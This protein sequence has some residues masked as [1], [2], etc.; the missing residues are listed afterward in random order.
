MT[1]ADFKEGETFGQCIRGLRR[2]RN[3]TQRDLAAQLG[4]DFTYLSKLE[5]DRGEIPAETTVRRLA[6]LLDVDPEELLSL[7]GRVPSE[8]RERAR[9]DVEFARFLRSLPDLPDDEVQR[10]HKSLKKRSP[11]K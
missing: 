9:D 6:E 4:I 11:G 7:A 1:A 10:L 3:L 2:E 8:L 5:N